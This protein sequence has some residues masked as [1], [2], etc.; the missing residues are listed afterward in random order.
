MAAQDI[1]PL[2]F[3]N[4]RFRGRGSTGVE[5]L[6]LNDPSLPKA[7]IGSVRLGESLPAVFNGASIR[8]RQTQTCAR[9]NGHASVMGITF[10]LDACR[11]EEEDVD[12]RV[13]CSS[14]RVLEAAWE[15]HTKI[16][17]GRAMPTEQQKRNEVMHAI[18][19]TSEARRR[20]RFCAAGGR[21]PPRGGAGQWATV[22]NAQNDLFPYC[23]CDANINASPYRVDQNYTDLGNSTYCWRITAVAPIT[24][25]G[26][27]NDADVR[28]F[29]I[30]SKLSCRPTRASATLNGEFTSLPQFYK[31]DGAPTNIQNLMVT[32]LALDVKSIGAGATLCISLRGICDTIEKLA[33]TDARFPNADATVSLVART[34][35]TYCEVFTVAVG[36][37]KAVDFHNGFKGNIPAMIQIFQNFGLICQ[38]NRLLPPIQVYVITIEYVEPLDSASGPGANVLD[39]IEFWAKVNG[40]ARGAIQSVQIDGVPYSYSWGPALQDILKITQINM[41]AEY[42][43]SNSPTITFTFRQ[44]FSL[45]Q[46]FYGEGTLTYAAFDDAKVYCPSVAIS[47]A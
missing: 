16:Q 44:G 43:R 11:T 8:V 32:G 4:C 27:C 40:P 29:E 42:V 31:P 21:G 23:D 34:N 1:V 26:Q 47:L 37:Q 30:R 45:N 46:L 22:A 28:K 33:S 36:I 3:W 39:K 10:A 15:L 12:T 18:E 7:T 35:S 6:A 38:N 2:S 9:G 14:W 25:S 41:T 5:W 19:L 17:V 24:A 20:S 13:G